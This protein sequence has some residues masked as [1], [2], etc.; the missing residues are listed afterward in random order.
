M[1]L[2]ALV[3]GIGV[4]LFLRFYSTHFAQLATIDAFNA[5]QVALNVERGVGL[6]TSVVYPMH[7]ALGD[8][9]S[10][11]H[12]INTGPLYPLA[13]GM[14]FKARGAED[15]SVAVFNGILMLLTAAFL[16]GLLKLVYDKSIAVWAVLAFFISMK[17]ISQA[18]AAGG[19][20]IGGLVVTA[21]LYFGMLAVH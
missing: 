9:W 4:G 19:A 21:A 11:R 15:R 8:A 7:A 2:G 10:S 20:T 16:Y 17:A 1:L 12:D 14:F 3:I 13:M 6:K 18:L 5:A